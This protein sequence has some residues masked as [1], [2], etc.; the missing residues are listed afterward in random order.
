MGRHI[1]NLFNFWI[2]VYVAV[3]STSCSYGL[4]IIGSTAG[5]PSFFKSLNLEPTPGK[6]GYDRTASLLGAFNGVNA[7]G[8][9]LGAF[10]NAY[11]ANRFSRK[12]T[13]QIGA[14]ILI[15][16]AALCAGSVNVAMFM[17]ARIIAGYGIGIL[18]AVSGV[19]CSRNRC[20]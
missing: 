5:Q 4:A 19:G 12:Y 16:G 13:I 10:S 1:P 20:I 18:T 9:L 15:V 2:V 8:A 6:P 3:G 17:V 14:S 11:L 7:A